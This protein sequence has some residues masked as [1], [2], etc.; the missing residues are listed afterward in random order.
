MK[1]K[2]RGYD[3]HRLKDP[4]KF[5][6]RLLDNPPQR[7]RRC[8]A[9]YTYVSRIDENTLRFSIQYGQQA[10]DEEFL[11][12]SSNNTW[13]ITIEPQD[14]LP[15]HHNRMYALM[16]VWV[17]ANKHGYSTHENPIRVYEG[18]WM[19]P[20]IPYVKGVQVYKGKVV[21]REKYVDRVRAIDKE[22]AKP[23][24][25]KLKKVRELAPIMIRLLEA[26]DVKEPSW[27]EARELKE[28]LFNEFDPNNVTA[29]DAE[30]V[31][32]IGQKTT[33]R[34]A[35]WQW[36]PS[37]ANRLYMETEQQYHKRCMVNGLRKLRQHVYSKEGVYQYKP[38]KN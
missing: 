20:T 16:T 10:R 27:Q 6:S 28:Q 35:A 29:L 38:V 22:A 34:R 25:K 21:D 30:R 11:Q 19:K 36:H 13:T 24:I 5:W 18:G 8:I 17:Q 15:R 33:Q 7:K 9:S 32:R 12:L 37:G 14:V 3:E 26:H 1:M 31:F 4:Y 2:V 23:V